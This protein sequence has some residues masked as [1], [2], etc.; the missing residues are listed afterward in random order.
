MFPNEIETQMKLMSLGVLK[1]EMTCGK[2][3]GQMRVLKKL[4]K[5]LFRYGKNTCGRVDVSIRKDS[6]FAGSKLPCRKIMKIAVA[7]LQGLSRKAAVRASKV[8]RSQ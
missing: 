1:S 8:T 5:L 4:E 3:G 7:W 6:V 2:C